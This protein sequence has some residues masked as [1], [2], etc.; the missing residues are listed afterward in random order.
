MEH[1]TFLSSGSLVFSVSWELF[2]TKKTQDQKIMPQ[3]ILIERT[4]YLA[5]YK[6][7]TRDVSQY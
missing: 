2:L 3:I 6:L 5:G 1:L 7:F 4:A